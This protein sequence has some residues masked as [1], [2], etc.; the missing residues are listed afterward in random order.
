MSEQGVAK[1]ASFR[2]LAAGAETAEELSEL[3]RQERGRLRELN[4]AQPQGLRAC[5]ALTEAT[6]LALQRMLHLSLPSD[7]ARRDETRA[8]IAVVATGGYGRRELCPYSDIDVTFVVAEEEDPALDATVRRM[9][10]FLMEIFSQRVGLKVGYAYRSLADAAQLDHQTQTAL[11]DARVVVGSHGLAERFLRRVF[12]HMWPA[13]YVRQKTAERCR[14]REKHGGTLYRIEPEVKEGPGGLR[15]LHLAEWLAA[16]SFPSTRGDVWRQ[17]QRIGAVSRRDVQQVQAAREFLL[18]VRTRMHWETGR[19][20]DLLVRERQESLAVALGFQDDDRASRV[21][22]LME[23]Y[24]A[25]AEN[26]DRV[27]GFVVERCLSERLSLT[28]E[29]VCSGNEL[30]PA[31]PWVKIASPGFLVELGQHYQEHGLLPGHE[32]RRMI[33]E[34]LESCP[35]LS[36]DTEAAEDFVGLLRAPAAPENGAPEPSYSASTAWGRGGRRSPGVFETLSLL[37]ELGVLQKLLP[38]IGE[39]YRRVP[40]DQVHRHTIGH[41]CLETVRFL[42][43]LRTTTEE[44]RQEL[45]RAWSE[46]DAPELLF[47]GGLLHDIGKLS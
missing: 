34:H 23:R 37:A 18:T 15:D 1:P 29:L 21:E 27:G 17:L 44:R 47:L 19:C 3:L 31:Y 8:K 7:P 20:A 10:L 22:R 4:E 40:F 30:S 13:A 16:V 41:H 38:E 26:L 32:L 28:D 33:G 25:H 9:F 45:R 46:V 5:R 36:V 43:N 11:L 24:Y 35:D 39:A 12:Q 14:S 42:E 2:A 6:D